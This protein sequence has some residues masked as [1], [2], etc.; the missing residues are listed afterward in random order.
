MMNLPTNLP[1]NPQSMIQTQLRQLQAKNPQAFQKINSLMQS[2]GNPRGLLQQFIGSAKSEQIQQL[3]QSAKGM[4][5]P[6][7]VLA[8]IQNMQSGKKAQK[9]SGNEPPKL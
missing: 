7:S 2:G 6:D 4:G 8:E 9:N 3:M 5:C 1:I